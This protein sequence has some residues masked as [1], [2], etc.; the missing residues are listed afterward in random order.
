MQPAESEQ[1]LLGEVLNHGDEIL[2]AN[3]GVGGRGNAA[4]YTPEMQHSFVAEDG[5]VG[6]AVTLLLSLKLIADV[7]LVGFPNAGKSSLLRALSNATPEVA[8]YPFTTLYPHLGRV[9]A[10]ALP[11]DEF[12]VADIPG[13]IDGAHANRG[14][15]HNFLRHIERTSLLCYVL[16]LSDQS[17]PAFEQL[18]SL[19]DELELYKGGLA[20]QP[21]MIVA[22][23][24]DMPDAQEALRHLR[25][26]I[27]KE[28]ANGGLRGL[29]VSNVD[30]GGDARGDA[31]GSSGGTTAV[32]VVSALH[33]KNLPRLVHRMLGN[34]RRARKILAG[35]ARTL[36][37]QMEE[38]AQ[39]MRRDA[40]QTARERRAAALDRRG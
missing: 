17:K 32:T 38:Q 24:A 37:A 7:G 2:V 18:A 3:G 27:A 15:G 14:L 9:R 31:G 1:I 8:S 33:K 35:D 23:K 19:Q 34:L 20:S 16:D 26:A 28:R 10:S 22:N 39:S 29:L 12:T 13:I 21:C 40:M 11:D 36:A 4:F 6:E 30:G 5:G 25:A